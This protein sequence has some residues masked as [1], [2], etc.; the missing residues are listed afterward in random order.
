VKKLNEGFYQR[1]DTIAIAKE[2]LG[3]ILVTNWPEGITSG[4]IV[5]TEAYLGAI[6][7]ASH[8]YGNRKTNRTQVMFQPGGVAYVYLC[9]GIHHLFNIVTGIDDTPHVVLIRALEPVQGLDL[10]RERTGSSQKENRIAAGPGK[11]TKA[12]GLTTSHSGLSLIDDEVFILDDGSR[13]SKK[14]IIADPRIGVDYAGEDAFLPYRFTILNN[15][16]VSV[17]PQLT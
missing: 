11:L 6:D 17:K 2:L 12:L 13:I 3:K 10:M 7:K 15:A 4:R 1:T 9:Y 8:A 16:S 14:E 5:E